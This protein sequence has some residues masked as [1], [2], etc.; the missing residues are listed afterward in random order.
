[1]LFKVIDPKLNPFYTMQRFDGPF[2]VCTMNATGAIVHEWKVAPFHA[3][4][5]VLTIECVQQ[6]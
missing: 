2:N 1:M 3:M 6:L 4:G 5:L